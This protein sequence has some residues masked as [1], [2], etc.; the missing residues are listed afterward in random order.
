MFLKNLENSIAS[1]ELD[2]V[3]ELR[4][5]D[6]LTVELIFLLKPRGHKTV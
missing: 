4:L 3:E 1:A 6:R 2:A 5:T